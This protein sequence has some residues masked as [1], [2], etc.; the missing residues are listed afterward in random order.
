MQIQVIE[1][2]TFKDPSRGALGILD[3][4][5]EIPFPTKRIFFHHSLFRTA[6]RG[7]HA[8]KVCRQL[9]IPISGKCKLN[10]FNAHGRVELDFLGGGVGLLIPALTWVEL[11]D[12]TEDFVSITLAD[13]HFDP[14]DYIVELSKFQVSHP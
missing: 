12:F 1:I 10:L 13:Q 6:K 2:K 7:E 3:C 5:D 14:E 11:E 9:M 8:H 4:I